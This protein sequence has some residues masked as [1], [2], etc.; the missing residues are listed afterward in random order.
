MLKIDSLARRVP[1]AVWRY[2]LSIVSV[3]VA[4]GITNSLERYTTLRTPLFYIAIIVS[5][6]FGGMWPGLLAVVLSTLAVDYYFAPGS[7]MPALSTDRRPFILLFSLSAL[8]A[9]WISV[10][11]RR[12]EKAL[13]R[14]RN[15]LEA[16]VEERTAKLK[17][18]NEE[19]QAE[20]TE[21]KRVEEKMRERVNLLDLTHDTVFVRD[22]NDVIT[23]WNRGAEGLYDWKKAEAIGQVSHH[24]MQTIFPAP[25]EEINE[26][27]LSKGRW[28]GML[29]HTKRD[30]TQVVV[31]SRWSLQRDE[32]KRPAAILETNNDITERKRAEEEMQ[33]ARAELAHVTRV[34]TLG[35]MT[36]SIA[37]EVNQ[38]LA[39]IVT[40]ANACLRWLARQDPDLDEAREAVSRI[41]KDGNRASE[42][43]GRIRA[44]VKKSPP[45]KNR[46]NI[47]QI[48]LEVIALAH[49]EVHR[50]RVSLQT[51]LSDDLPLVLADRIQLQQ[52]ILNLIINGIEAMSGVRDGAREL[53]VSAGR[54]N[55]NGVIV[56]VRDSGKG[57]DSESLD[58]L[59]DAF[60]TT[61]P[62]GMGMG[63]A[64][65]RSIIEAHGG[66]LWATLN[67]PQGAVFQFTL[68]ADGEKTL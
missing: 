50:N 20:I 33:K 45:R 43:V 34:G 64:I 11:R 3:A 27:L 57:L 36:A 7:R 65:S 47:N 44:L 49:N 61:K 46:L 6:W 25:L 9:C 68:P 62:D 31:A 23:F 60:F 10:Q 58:H 48:I 35:E 15:E 29:I 24:L 14:A 16:R 56:A 63:L 17:R 19:L 18:V 1:H 67:S 26:E 52:V 40:N 28:E 5:A 38:P 39:A 21:R 22:M 4:L 8:F 12:A 66:R 2:G 54:H 32:Q 37:H 13:K 41:I 59:F 55:S 53:L 42:V 30:G 51:Q